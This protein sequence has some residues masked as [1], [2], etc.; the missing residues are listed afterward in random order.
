MFCAPVELIEEIYTANDS[1]IEFKRV[2]PDR[3]N[4]ADDIVAFANAQGG[5]ILIGV[6]EHRT[7]V[8]I[9]RECLDIVEKT[10]VDVCLC[11]IDPTV[12][13]FHRKTAA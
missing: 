4:L 2:L 1:R 7:I 6:D 13:C 5:A 10:V 8:G 9:D 12:S 11:N 3:N